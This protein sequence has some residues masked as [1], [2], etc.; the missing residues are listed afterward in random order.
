MVFDLMAE[1]YFI[2]HIQYFFI[3]S[4]VEDLGCPVSD[5]M[6]KAAMNMVVQLYMGDG[7]VPFFI[8]PEVVCPDGS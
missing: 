8:C 1:Y 5:I 4:S 6:N 7:G 2:V 3:H